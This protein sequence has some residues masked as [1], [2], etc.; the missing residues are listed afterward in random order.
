MGNDYLMTEDNECGKGHIKSPGTLT[1]SWTG[2]GHWGKKGAELFCLVFV[3]LQVMPHSP[4]RSCPG[5][6][7][8]HLLAQGLLQMMFL[9]LEQLSGEYLALPTKENGLLHNSFKLLLTFG[10]QRDPEAGNT[11]RLKPGSLG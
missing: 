10:Y 7:P 4:S 8:P 9:G 6:L 5:S 3:V 2:L 11:G 1:V